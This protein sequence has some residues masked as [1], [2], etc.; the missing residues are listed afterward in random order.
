MS[1][2]KEK[3]WLPRKPLEMKQIKSGQ[4]DNAVRLV[5]S[6]HKLGHRKDLIA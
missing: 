1:C 6:G 2:D 5:M 3:T 4:M